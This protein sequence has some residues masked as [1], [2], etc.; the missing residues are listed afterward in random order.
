[1]PRVRSRRGRSEHG[2]GKDRRLPEIEDLVSMP[3]E[4]SG[5]VIAGPGTGK[6]W[7]IG[8]RIEALLK[9]DVNLDEIV[10]VTLTNETVRSL[11]ARLPSAR[12]STLHSYALSQLNALG[13][14]VRRRMADR[15]EERYL[16]SYDIQLL[17]RQAKVKIDVDDVPAFL[18]RLGAGFRGTADEAPKLT[19]E[20]ELLRSAW[21]RV[22]DFLRIRLP[23]EL[24][25]DLLGLLQEGHDL[26]F[27][28]RAVLVD[29]YQDLTPV[30]LLLIREVSKRYGV[31]VFACGDDRQSIYGF[32]EADALGLNNFSDVYVTDGPA[33][34]SISHRCPKKIVDLAEQVAGHM[35]AV[36]GISDRPPLTSSEERGDGELRVASFKSPQA[37]VAWV[38]RDIA[39]RRT[40]DEDAQV[41]V[42]VARGVRAY[43]EYLNAASEKEGLSTTFADSRTPSAIRDD[44]GFRLLYAL[45][46][47]SADADDQ[48]AWRALVAIARGIGKTRL[49]RM[50]REYDLLTVA[51]RGLAATDKAVQVLL[52]SV[53]SARAAIVLA[54]GLDPVKAA[55][56]AVADAIGFVEPIPW[57]VIESTLADGELTAEPLIHET[58]LSFCS[59]LGHR[60]AADEDPQDGRILVYT[61]HGSK[62]QQWDHVYLV[63]AAVQAFQ[64]RVPAD[65]L[66]RLYVAITRSRVSLAVTL[67]RYLKWTPLA[68]TLGVEA[69]TFLPAFVES[70][71]AVGVTRQR[72]PAE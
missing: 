36:P 67:A 38:V 45:L 24:N 54:D 39:R 51:L 42:V 2:A 49:E 37:E 16:V 63:G 18:A 65:G 21:L 12:I 56:R 13:D 19:D 17:A 30:E 60:T 9:Q 47:V 71:D 61:V 4:S 46:R 7:R 33:Y 59:E 53:G 22:R 57:E 35:P 20:E 64:D 48:L 52:D 69:T 55:V 32:R 41:A 25:Y 68:K 31:G 43:V 14:A 10:V 72:D 66:R 29:E 50:Y 34:L 27:P 70:C 6:T 58:L 26:P 23:D 11:K 5:V 44:L 1:M 8:E 28:P 40:A 62:G 15:W 3:P